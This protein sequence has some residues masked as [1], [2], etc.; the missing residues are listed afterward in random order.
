VGREISANSERGERADSAPDGVQPVDIGLGPS[1]ALTVAVFALVAAVTAAGAHAT[2]GASGGS[3]ALQALARGT[4]VAVPLAVGLY[5]W[6]RPAHARYGRLLVAFT[7]VWLLAALSSSSSSTV[8]SVGRVAGWIAEFVT[9]YALL[10]F[11]TGRL[12]ARADR[13][14]I[15]FAAAT[16]VVLY[17]PTALLVHMYPAPSPWSACIAHCPP[18][19]FMVVQHEPAIIASVVNPL[20]D[21]LIVVVVAL[22]ALRLAIRAHDA[23]A[24]VRRTVLP[25]LAVASARMFLFA[26]TL[27]SRRIDPGWIGTSVLAWTLQLLVPVIGLTFL[28]GL[29]RWD[30]FIMR[31]VAEVNVKLRDM[32]GPAQVRKLLADAFEDPRLNIATWSAK[33]A[34][35]IDAAG[36]P[37]PDPVSGEGRA[38]TEVSGSRGPAVA[39]VHDAAFEDDPSFV[40]TAATAASV[41]FETRRVADRTARIVAE[42][43]ASRARILAAAD[44]E[45]RRIERDLHDGA[46]QRLVALMIHL[47]V[48]AEEAEDEHPEEAAE[49]RGL[50][51]QVVEALDEM[52]SLT[53]EIYPPTLAGGGLASAVRS[54]TLRS[55]VAARFEEEGLGEYP[56]EIASAVYFCCVEALQNVAKHA[57]TATSVR[58]VL[59]ERDSALYFSV[60]DD[61]PGMVDPGARVGAGLVNMEDRVTTVGG[62]LTI[63][64]GPRQGTVVTGRIPIQLPRGPLLLVP[65]TE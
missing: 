31:A 59:R 64:S 25:V 46:Q 60:I 54:A 1:V 38:M 62:K 28:V 48:A 22:V 40:E 23:T 50:S 32:P 10:A 4:I 39:I 30:S 13:I 17:L 58:V 27:I 8:Y 57:R 41:A 47:G 34:R 19:A 43:K 2:T 37:L 3:A 12:E 18:N 15:G 36:A 6:R 29:G 14:L 7:G 63:R 65:T 56:P 35:W 16:I 45:R 20:R 5:A 49:L 52:R 21:V 26:L 55:P 53:R 51:D 33:R 42:L 11:P 24:L 61:G 44:D 9:A